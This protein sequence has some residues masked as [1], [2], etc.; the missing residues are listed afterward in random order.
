MIS[1]AVNNSNENFPELALNE[2]QLTELEERLEMAVVN[3]SASPD[4][5]I[6]CKCIHGCDQNG[7]PIVQ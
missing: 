6:C 4:M 7:N 3:F 5:T 1:H 2:F